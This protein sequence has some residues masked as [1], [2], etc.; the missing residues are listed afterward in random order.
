MLGRTDNRNKI[1]RIMCMFMLM[2]IHL[3]AYL[4]ETIHVFQSDVPAR[5]ERNSEN[6]SLQEQAPYQAE[7][8]D[9]SY[10]QTSTRLSQVNLSVYLLSLLCIFRAAFSKIRQRFH[11]VVPAYVHSGTPRPYL[12]YG[13]L[14]I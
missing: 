6:T 5:I 14:L 10:A 2:L 3:D 12:V 4:Y 9:L 8:G 1:F 7:W 13:S 11:R